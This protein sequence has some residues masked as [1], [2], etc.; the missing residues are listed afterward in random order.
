MKQSPLHVWITPLLLIPPLLEAQS[1]ANLRQQ[2]SISDRESPPHIIYIM[3]DDL[4]YGDFSCYG[5]TEYATPHVDDFA[6]QGMKFNHAYAAAPVCTP[7]RVAFM[8]GQYPARNELGLREPLTMSPDDQ[9]LGLKPGLPT[10]SSLLKAA[11]YETALFG[12]WHLGFDKDFFPTRH[13]FDHFF[14]IIAGAADYIDHRPVT[15]YKNFLV[16]GTLPILYE[17]ETPVKRNGYLADLVTDAAIAF[18]RGE[19]Q[20]P[21][22]ISLQYTSPHWPWQAPGSG[23]VPDTM[24]YQASGNKEDFARIMTNLD[25]NIGKLLDAIQAAGLTDNTLVILTSDNGGERYSNMNPF[26]GYKMQLWEGGIRVPALVRW[27]GKVKAGSASNQPVITMDWT[28]SILEAAGYKQ[29]NKPDADGISLLNHLIHPGDIKS[30]TFFWRTS[31]RVQAEALRQ[32]DWKYLKTNEGEFLFDLKNDPT[33]TR[34]LA[35]EHPEKLKELK[36]EFRKIS[37]T[38]LPPLVLSN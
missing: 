16:K 5:Q 27:P 25:E 20:R 10:V 21:F 35:G 28:A 26:K 38:M 19:H 13:G 23:P 11:G 15:R 36:S 9:H 33:E 14:G 22:F 34:N 4:G 1:S 37:G 32:G 12:K 31:N 8:T 24:D 3:V 6:K 29:K 30:R 17:N 18:I 2:V 7:T